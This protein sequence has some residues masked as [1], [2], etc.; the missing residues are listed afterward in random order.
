[1]DVLAP[2]L[3]PIFRP[4]GIELGKPVPEAACENS[5]GGSRD[6][7][8]FRDLRIGIPLIAHLL[9]YLLLILFDHTHR[10][11]EGDDHE[12]DGRLVGGDRQDPAG[13]AAA[14]IPD[15]SD[16]PPGQAPRF[17]HGGDGVIGQERRQRRR[18]PGQAG[19]TAENSR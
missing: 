10:E 6:L 1:M 2:G 7:E 8:R 19:G 17:T 16:S 12:I 11:L 5:F 13:L 14:L 9:L 4:H 18:Y 15:P 3:A